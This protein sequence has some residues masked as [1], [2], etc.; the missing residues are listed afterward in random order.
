[1]GNLVYSTRNS[2]PRWGFHATVFYQTPCGWKYQWL[3]LPAMHD[4]PHPTDRF[5]LNRH[6]LPK[7]WHS[8]HNNPLYN[9]TSLS[10]FKRFL[11]WPG[12]WNELKLDA[13]EN[14]L[15]ALCGARIGHLYRYLLDRVETCLERFWRW[16]TRQIVRCSTA[17]SIIADRVC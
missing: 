4:R 11:H 1:M 9:G 13:H 12:P 2:E 17:R 8:M 14:R 10:L 5:R 6:Q 15:F 3:V 16:S 7:T